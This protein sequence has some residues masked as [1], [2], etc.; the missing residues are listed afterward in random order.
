MKKVKPKMFVIYRISTFDGKAECY[1]YCYPQQIWTAELK[2]D[3]NKVTLSRKNVS[4][5]IPKE[6]FESRWKVVE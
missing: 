3:K 1:I 5:T 2:A 6:D 4:F